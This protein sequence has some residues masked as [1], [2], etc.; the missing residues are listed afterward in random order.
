MSEDP[1]IQIIRA[2]TPVQKLQAA[3]RLY[4]SAKQLKA[5]ALRAQHPDWTEDQIHIAVRDAFLYARE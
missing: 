1:Y 5:A 3:E 2:M 4:E